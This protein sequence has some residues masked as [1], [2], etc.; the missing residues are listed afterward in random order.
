M[1]DT[2]QTQKQTPQPEKHIGWHVIAFLDLLGQQDALRKITALPNIENI[3][4]VDAFKQ[5]IGE[6]Y[7]PLYALRSFF[8]TGIT[9]FIE[10]GIDSS[11][12][13]TPQQELLK[14]FR[15]TPIHYRFFSDS[16]IVHIPLR[17][18]IGK[19][20]CR[21]IFGVLAA[22][23]QTFLSCMSKGWAIRGGIELGL[24]MDI[25]DTEVYGPALARAYT[26]ESKVAQYPRVVIGEELIR[27][28]YEVAGHE[29]TT[30]EENAH[31]K[32]AEMAIRIFAVDDD[33]QTFLDYLGDE[34]QSLMSKEMVQ[35][36]YNFTIQESIKHKECK[37]SKLG[38]RYTLLRNYFESRI[39]KWEI[40]LQTES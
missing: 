35:N 37:N 5:K 24:A 31:A 3:E 19:F 18:D 39:N 27:Y 15:S 10:G 40:N 29:A 32:L 17:N 33:G 26:L 16:L 4:E 6:L 12:L 9:P 1:K 20:P 11:E 38:F 25:D 14:E 23:A 36:A 13:T 28:L 22:S 7:A 34:I 21:A 30:S 2:Q 8:Q